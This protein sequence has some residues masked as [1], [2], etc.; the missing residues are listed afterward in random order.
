MTDIE[1]RN[2]RLHFE[3]TTPEELAFAD[4]IED[5]IRKA[6]GKFRPEDKRATQP[7]SSASAMD[8]HS[9]PC[10]VDFGGQDENGGYTQMLI[11]TPMESFFLS[12]VRLLYA[13]G[14][15]QTSVSFH[16]RGQRAGLTGD[17]IVDR[18]VAKLAELT[19]VLGRR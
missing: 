11:R 5:V 17:A 16:K 12:S 1:T 14:Q 2:Q 19:P 6:Q 18:A 3:P 13:P 10:T 15:I 7:L 9:I 8:R 4:R